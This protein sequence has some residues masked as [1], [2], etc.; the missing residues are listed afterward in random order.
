[1]KGVEEMQFKYEKE[2]LM[3]QMAFGELRTS[4]DASKGYKP[5]E[6]LLASLTT[7]SGSLLV[8][9]LQKKRISFETVSFTTEANRNPE[10]TNRIEVV[11]IYAHVTFH[12][13][14]ATSQLVKLEE[15]VMKNCSMIQTMIGAVTIQFNVMSMKGD[16]A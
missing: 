15:L 6:L 5:I 7:C 3:G 14:I 13:E 2:Y 16:E 1:M 11:N 8:N 12:Q 10:R 9:L 4:T